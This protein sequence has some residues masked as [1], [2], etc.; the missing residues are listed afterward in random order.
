MPGDIGLRYNSTLF[1]DNN[2][3]RKIVV[4]EIF[5]FHGRRRLYSISRSMTQVRKDRW[6]ETLGLKYSKEGG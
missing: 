4:K 1:A 2:T 5:K 3:P 6:K